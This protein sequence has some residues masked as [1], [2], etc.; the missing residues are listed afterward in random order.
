MSVMQWTKHVPYD[1]RQICETNIKS[2]FEF[3]NNKMFHWM[4]RV[5]TIL[6]NKI[7]TH[8]KWHVI[9]LSVVTFDIISHA[10]V[11]TANF[12]NEHNVRKL[13]YNIFTNKY[14]R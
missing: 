5:E 13:I 10:W 14:L 6:I 11:V 1:N 3:L 7:S 4:L 9:E 12:T 8:C 2:Y